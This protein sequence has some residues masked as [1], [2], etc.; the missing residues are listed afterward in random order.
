MPEITSQTFPDE[1]FPWKSTLTISK[2]RKRFREVKRK[3]SRRYLLMRQHRKKMMMMVIQ[4][5][6]IQSQAQHTVDQHGLWQHRH[7]RG[8]FG[9]VNHFTSRLA[10]SL[11]QV[12]FLVGVCHLPCRSLPGCQCQPF[13][14]QVLHAFIFIT[15][16]STKSKST[17]KNVAVV[18]FEK[19]VF[20]NA[21][22]L[23]VVTL[24]GQPATSRLPRCFTFMRTRDVT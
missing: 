11:S 1:T 3:H 14:E 19:P 21:R 7:A 23:G 10:E 18:C 22:T 20:S 4:Q 16:S 17:Y 13:T 5:I 8:Q 12:I 15:A 24:A 9:T 2:P 6:K